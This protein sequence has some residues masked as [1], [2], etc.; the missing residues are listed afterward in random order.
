[1]EVVCFRPGGELAGRLSVPARVL[2]PWD[3]GLNF[4]AP[5][6]MGVLKGLGAQA[7]L[8]M[9][10][11]ANRQ[12][13]KIKQGLPGVRVV[14]TQ[15]TGKTLTR[16]AL[17]ALR[18]ADGVLANSRWA[19]ERA[20]AAGV[21]AGRCVVVNNLLG[22]EP[23]V[24]PDTRERIRR[25]LD[26]DEDAVVLINVAGFRRGK[27]QAELLGMLAPLLREG[28]G[29][30][31]WLVGEGPERARCE[32]LA[33]VLNLRNRV[34]FTGRREDVPALLAAADLC[35][36]ASRMESQPNALIEAQVSGLPVVAWDW[37]GVREAFQPG[38]SGLCVGYGDVTGMQTAVHQLV[39]D[40]DLRVRMGEAGRR[41]AREAF[42]SEKNAQACLDFLVQP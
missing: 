27:G 3:T 42:D 33:G 34:C 15:R 1:M 6:L 2:Q 25:E 21:E 24:L 37:A 7:V 14:A 11:E 40:T 30:V 4:L 22:V 26:V 39:R 28:S 36:H 13:P 29:L 38:V 41:F 8:C 10:W 17:R 16:R 18:A 9:G 5:G 35:V 12:V 32:K 23:D 19:R 20:L 31:L